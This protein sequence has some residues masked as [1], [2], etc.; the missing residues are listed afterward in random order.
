MSLI[1][2][3]ISDVSSGV[4]FITS[5]PRYRPGT[6]RPELVLLLSYLLRSN[7]ITV[8]FYN[9]RKCCCLWR[10]VAVRS[11]LRFADER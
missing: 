3:S 2:T 1:T 9:V 5:P 11:C 7:R 10:T 6:F 8:T 4:H